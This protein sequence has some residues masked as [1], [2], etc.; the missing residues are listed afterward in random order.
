MRV[1]VEELPPPAVRAGLSSDGLRQLTEAQLRTAGVKVSGDGS[2]P[3]GDPYLRVMIRASPERAG[4]VACDLQ[5]DFVQI[6]F[7]RRNPAVTFN[8]A[9]TWKADA[10]PALVPAAQL[11]EAARRALAEQVGQFIDDYRAVNR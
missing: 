6:V 3:T 5:V 9:Q 11:A 8:R 1:A 2:F 10:Q 4:V 7:M